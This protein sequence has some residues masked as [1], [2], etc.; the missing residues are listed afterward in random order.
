MIQPTKEIKTLGT[1]E[2]V[3]NLHT[4]IQSIIKIK[5]ISKEENI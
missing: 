4:E 3:V 5:V 1:F 2:V